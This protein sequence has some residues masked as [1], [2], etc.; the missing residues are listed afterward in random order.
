MYSHFGNLDWITPFGVFFVLAASACWWLTRRNATLLGIDGS[1]IDLVL[2]M[3]IIA[4]LAGGVLLSILSPADRYLTGELMQTEFRVRLFSFIL[5]GAALVFVYSRATEQS[6]RTLLDALALP[7]VLGLMI[8]RV[9]CFLAGCCWGDISV[10]SHELAAIANTDL[11]Y[12]IQT[13]PWLAGEWVKTG[14]Q[15]P[16]GSFPFEQHVVLGLIGADAAAS[17]PVHPA[18]LYE[19]GLLFLLLL[20]MKGISLNKYPRGTITVTASVAYAAIRF[21]IEFVRADG[22]VA[23]NSLTMTQVQCIALALIGGTVLLLTQAQ[24]RRAAA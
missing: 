5:S 9:G 12:Q 3:S 1:H 14:V 13:L 22:T 24:A 4:G 18:Q 17:L 16:P 8:H 10:H 7:T 2:P 15:F 11:G 20:A 6:F 19:A 21:F 23:V